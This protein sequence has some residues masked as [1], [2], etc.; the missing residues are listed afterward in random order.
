MDPILINNHPY[1]VSDGENDIIQLVC[2][3]GRRFL[4]VVN[5]APRGHFSCNVPMV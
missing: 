3:G 1:E 4:V 5:P 2:R